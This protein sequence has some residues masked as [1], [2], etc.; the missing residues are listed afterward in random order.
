MPLHRHAWQGILKASAQAHI[1]AL[2]I[3]IREMLPLQSRKASSFS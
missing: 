1:A 2:G 3:Q